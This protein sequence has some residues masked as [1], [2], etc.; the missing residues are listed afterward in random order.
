LR[1]TLEY[2]RRRAAEYTRAADV[3][4][5]L[6]DSDGVVGAKPDVAKGKDRPPSSP[7]KKMAQAA[8]GPNSSFGKTI[9]VR[10]AD[11]LRHLKAKGHQKPEQVR[12]DL[13]W[14]DATYYEV[15]RC[16]WFAREYGK[17]SLTSAGEAELERMSQANGTAPCSP[18]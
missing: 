13:A 18:T 1:N 4:Q 5:G 8:A 3:L 11:L 10:R 15:V 9:F 17:V 2:L 16:D 12:A 7:R 14:S 6:L